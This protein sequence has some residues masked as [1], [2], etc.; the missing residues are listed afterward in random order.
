[1]LEKYSKSLTARPLI[2][3]SWTSASLYGIQEL[4][5]SILSNTKFDG[6]KA[7]KM[8]LYGKLKLNLGFFVSGPI[9][10]FLYGI[11][12]RLLQGKTGPVMPVAKLLFSNLIINP[13]MNACYLFCLSSL[14]GANPAKAIQIVKTR[15]LGLMKISWLISPLAQAFAFKN[16]EP[17]FY[18]PFFNLI[19]FVFGT[20]V[21]TRAKLEASKKEK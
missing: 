10:H 1:L 14:A 9:G 13:I 4:V 8:S 17:K 2:T 16:L 11:M 7:L 21:N 18:L 19:A 12:E 15:L 6:K 3:K 20:A 5:S